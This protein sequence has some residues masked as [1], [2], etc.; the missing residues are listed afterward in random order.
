MPVRQQY[1]AALAI[2]GLIVVL[3]LFAMFDYF[4]DRSRFAERMAVTPQGAA[5]FAGAMPHAA[6]VNP[7]GYSTSSCPWCGWAV[8]GAGNSQCRNCGGFVGNAGAGTRPVGTGAGNAQNAGFMWF[9]QEPRKPAQPPGVLYCTAC[10]FV[11]ICKYTT[12]PNSIQCPRCASFLVLSKPSGA[13]APG[14]GGAGR[15]AAFSPGQVMGPFV[16][17]W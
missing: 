14:R 3:V 7:L 5:S 4:S 13:T 17:A 2:I 10:D 8:A 1:L 6:G 9:Q 15:P 11:M 16:R 12:V